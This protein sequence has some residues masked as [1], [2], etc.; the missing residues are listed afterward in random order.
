LAGAAL[1]KDIGRVHKVSSGGLE[2]AVET[3]PKAGLTVL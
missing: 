1:R 2:S 3:R